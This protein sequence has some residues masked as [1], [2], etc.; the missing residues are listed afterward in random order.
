MLHLCFAGGS[1]PVPER[2]LESL[3]DIPLV[4]S[5]VSLLQEA[6]ARKTVFCRKFFSDCFFSKHDAQPP[7][8]IT[9]EEERYFS[10]DN[11]KTIAALRSDTENLL[12]VLAGISPHLKTYSDMFNAARKHKDYVEC[13]RS[14]RQAIAEVEALPLP[15]AP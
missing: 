13:L 3:S 6:M 11:N 10:D 7:V 9:A 1:T 15:S 5:A 8:F 12:G 2:P 4:Q 14:I